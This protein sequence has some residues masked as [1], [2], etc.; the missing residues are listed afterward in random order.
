MAGKRDG[1]VTLPTNNVAFPEGARVYMTGGFL[2][3]A[4]ATQAEI[5]VIEKGTTTADAYA[6]VRLLPGDTTVDYI[7]NGAISQYA[8][9]FRAANGRVAATG[10][11][12][13]T[14]GVATQAA[15]GA[16]AVIEGIPCP[17]R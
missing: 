15:S 11:A 13:H 17:A 4:G 7:A 1:I 5:G 10:T 9:M 2:A 8:D 6:A 16:G 12:G 3:L 14:I